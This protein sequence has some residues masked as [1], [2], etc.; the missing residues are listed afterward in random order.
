MPRVL[1]GHAVE[2]CTRMSVSDDFA[3]AMLRAAAAAHVSCV[4]GRPPAVA[5]MGA[6]SAASPL[7]TE[8][9]S[10]IAPFVQPASPGAGARDVSMAT[11]E[12]V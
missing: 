12:E 7:L 3:S 6:A 10:G 2:K 1:G 9:V 11:E 8:A 4:S 5:A